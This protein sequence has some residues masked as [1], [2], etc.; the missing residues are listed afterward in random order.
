[1][2]PGALRQVFD[3]GG[4]PAVALDQKN[5]AGLQRVAD[6][7]GGGRVKRRVAAGRLRQIF[8]DFGAEIGL[9]LVE[10][11]PQSCLRAKRFGPQASVARYG[12]KG[13]SPMR[14]CNISP[15]GTYSL[16]ANHHSGG[17][18]AVAGKSPGK[19]DVA[20]IVPAGLPHPADLSAGA[21]SPT[22][23]VRHPRRTRH[24]RRW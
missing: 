14:N 17:A 6:D 5:V 18:L 23:A 22:A 21:A 12:P 13:P 3:S 19:A 24:G 10:H 1:M 7:V 9:D 15:R 20:V 4:Q 16:A 2:R 8:E 11:E